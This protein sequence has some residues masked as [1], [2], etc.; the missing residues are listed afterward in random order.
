MFK[1]FG[2]CGNGGQT[3]CGA[4][5]DIYGQWLPIAP[6]SRRFQRENV[7]LLPYRRPQV[8]PP[9]IGTKFLCLIDIYAYT[10]REHFDRGS[11]WPPPRD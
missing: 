1:E 3:G 5:L 9:I 11:T 7:K 8:R 2:T 6:V 10:I 4:V